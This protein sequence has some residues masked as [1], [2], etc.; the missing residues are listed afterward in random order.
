MHETNGIYVYTLVYVTAVYRI[1]MPPL[2]TYMYFV[3][4]A[5]I[6]IDEKLL[7]IISSLMPFRDAP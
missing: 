4:I 3:S 5:R 6:N 7:R 1:K 2:T